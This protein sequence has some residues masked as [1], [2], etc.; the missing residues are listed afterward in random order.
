MSISDERP[1]VRSTTSVDPNPFP[2][3][4][5]RRRLSMRLPTAAAVAL[6]LAVT[7]GGV[8]GAVTTQHSSPAP[9]T[10]RPHGTP[11]VAEGTV[12]EVAADGFTLTTRDG[13]TVTVDVSSSTSYME[14]GT[15]STSLGAVTV[16]SHVTVFGAQGSDAVTATRVGIGLPPI[17]TGTPPNGGGGPSTGSWSAPSMPPNRSPSTRTSTTGTTATS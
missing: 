13:T 17:R 4:R 1:S 7:S 5:R 10:T 15:S 2:M 11:P 16:G 14:F 9:G 12:V 8:A 6:G 3:L